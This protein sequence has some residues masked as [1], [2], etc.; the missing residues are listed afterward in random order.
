MRLLIKD[1]SLISFRCHRYTLAFPGV[2]ALTKAITGLAETYLIP[3]VHRYPLE[4]NPI[5]ILMSFKPCR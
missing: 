3:S 2:S 4:G 5:S 1:F